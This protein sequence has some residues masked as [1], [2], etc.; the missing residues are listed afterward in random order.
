[1]NYILIIKV[2]KKIG[3]FLRKINTLLYIFLS[4]IQDSNYCITN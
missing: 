2:Y 1:M 4:L 3:I